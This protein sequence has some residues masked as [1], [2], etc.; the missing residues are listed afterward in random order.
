MMKNIQGR[1][2]S[3]FWKDLNCY[4]ILFTFKY[5]YFEEDIKQLNVHVL[6]PIKKIWFHKNAI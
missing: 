5:I 6:L 4:L 3:P 1:L 2:Y